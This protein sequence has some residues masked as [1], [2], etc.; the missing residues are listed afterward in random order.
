[1]Q[2]LRCMERFETVA[3]M[4]QIRILPRQESFVRSRLPVLP[5]GSQSAWLPL[6]P[7]IRIFSRHTNIYQPRVCSAPDAFA[8]HQLIAAQVEMGRR[9][10][11]CS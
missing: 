6:K 7:V 11:L 8:Q 1:M 3:S 10:L 4:A 5:I 2:S 9:H